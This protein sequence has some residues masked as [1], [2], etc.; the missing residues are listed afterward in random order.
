MKFLDRVKIHLK[1]GDGGDG[2]ASFRREK[3]LEFGGPDG[4]DGGKGGDIWVHAINDLN[5]LID[6]RYTQ[7]IK[8][9][10]GQNGM[11][12]Q[13]T[14][15]GG[16][17]IIIKVPVGT[18]IFDETE[19]TLIVDMI[20]E[21]QKFLIAKGGDG[22]YGNIKFAT[23]TNR[24]P[25]KSTKGW[26]GEEFSIWMNL[27]LIANVGLVGFPNAGKSTLLSTVTRAKA[28]AAAYPFTTLYPQLG[29]V[30]MH[31]KEFVMADLPGLI[32]GAHEG[33]GLGHRFLAHAERCQLLLHL[34][35][36]T[37]EDIVKQYDLIRNELV[38]YNEDLSKRP[39]IVVITKSDEV[40]DEEMHEK[41]TELE[42]HIK[43]DAYVISALA[44]K[45]IDPL[46]D[47]VFN[48]LK[49]DQDK[50]L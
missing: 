21:N 18:Q 16:S 26:P 32:E 4:G 43:T 24:A 25:R 27:K 6:Y 37:E 8:S 5:T 34:I 3:F 50:E 33:V 35:D 20:E 39:E 11:G 1:S 48:L 10:R 30:R 13:R 28:K 15:K 17:D 22:G 49:T 7:H 44:R 42:K 47:K 19:E 9:E 2:C 29:V 40:L 23:S 46:L 41:K 45:N 38:K 14:G 12:R 36:G 31:D